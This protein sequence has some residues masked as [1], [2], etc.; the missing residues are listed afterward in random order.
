MLTPCTAAQRSTAK[1]PWTEPC[2]QGPYRLCI[3]RTRATTR[4]ITEE[5][6]ISH[7]HIHYSHSILDPVTN[8]T[9]ILPRQQ[10]PKQS[11]DDIST[12]CLVLCGYSVLQ[13][14]P[15]R[16]NAHPSLV[17]H[18]RFPASHSLRRI[19]HPITPANADSSFF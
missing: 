10:P 18:P 16:K 1:A 19:A 8:T 9:L 12:T 11:G 13:N 17:A 14:S 3:C 5:K 2:K 15:D 6:G 7:H 4:Q